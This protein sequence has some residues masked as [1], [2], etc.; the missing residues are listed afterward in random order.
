ML[1]LKRR[2]GTAFQGVRAVQTR[3]LPSQWLKVCAPPEGCFCSGQ[4]MAGRPFRCW[5]SLVCTE[6]KRAAR[7]WPAAQSFLA[8]ILRCIGSPGRALAG[9]RPS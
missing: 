7:G 2:A 5:A 9:R 1:D 6:A 3:P 8:G 4:Q